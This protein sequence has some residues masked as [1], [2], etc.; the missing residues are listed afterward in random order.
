M[1]SETC[2]QMSTTISPLV[3]ELRL[4]S[5]TQH[6]IPYPRPKRVDLQVE[7]VCHRLSCLYGKILERSLTDKNLRE[8][9]WYQRVNIPT[10]C[11]PRAMARAIFNDTRLWWGQPAITWATRVVILSSL[12]LHHLIRRVNLEGP[13]MESLQSSKQFTWLHMKSLLAKSP[14]ESQKRRK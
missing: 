10:V 2:Y 14:C 9:Q 12:S 1:T 11:K 8:P 3:I 5:D 4:Q 13:P 6:G 7:L